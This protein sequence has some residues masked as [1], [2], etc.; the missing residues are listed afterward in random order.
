MPK[1]KMP[2]GKKFP[3]GVSG[4]PNGR[5]KGR[6]SFI[7]AIKQAL[8]ECVDDNKG[9]PI[10]MRDALVKTLL[11]KALGGDMKALEYVIDRI[12]GKALQNV[13]MDARVEISKDKLH[14]VA[15]AIIDESK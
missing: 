9:D 7:P 15:K 10:Q 4:N 12:D 13:E 2:E 3:K 1:K 11:N 5:P 8:A 14:K 6:I